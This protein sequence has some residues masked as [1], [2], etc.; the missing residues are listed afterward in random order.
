MLL[1]FSF[2]SFSAAFPPLVEILFM[3]V[4]LIES[5]DFGAD[6]AKSLIRF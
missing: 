2:V 4:A 1:K 5:F 6:C 3:I